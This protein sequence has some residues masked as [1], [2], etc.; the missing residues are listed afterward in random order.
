MLDIKKLVKEYFYEGD[1]LG[2]VYGKTSTSF[3][4]WSPIAK[5]VELNIYSEGKGDCLEDKIPMMLEDKGTWHTI[6]E[7]DLDGKY[8]TYTIQTEKG[9]NEVTDVY[10]TAAGVNGNRAMVLDFQR[11]NPEGWSEDKGP[12]LEHKTDAI[13]SY[14]PFLS[15]LSVSN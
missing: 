10:A 4:V 7:G 2:C 12:E 11:T 3:R 15:L 6:V 9:T 5:K 13:I 8:Y 1:D 14:I